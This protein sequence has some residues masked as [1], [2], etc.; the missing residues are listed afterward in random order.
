MA[1]QVLN[2]RSSK[3]GKKPTPEQIEHGQIAVNYYENN[4]RIFIKNSTQNIIDFIPTHEVDKHIQDNVKLSSG[5]TESSLS[6]EELE[7]KANETF[8]VAIGKLH[9]AIKDNEVVES[10]AFD[11]FRNSCGFDNNALY[12]PKNELISGTT[13]LSDAM[14]IVAEKINTTTANVSEAIEKIADEVER[15]GYQETTYGVAYWNKDELNPE[16]VE[17]FG[18]KDFLLDYD[19]YLID[20]TDNANKTTTPVGKL[21]KNNLLRFENGNFAPTIGITEAQ[22]AE[23]DVELYLDAEHQQKYCEAGSFNAETFYNEHGMAKLYNSDGAEVRVLRPWETVET[24]YSI[25]LG[26]DKTVYVLDNVVG[27]SG[28]KWRGVFLK[29]T[30]WDGFDVTPYALAPTGISP[31]PITTVGGKARTFLYLYKGETNCQS[32]K[33]QNNLCTMFFDQEKTYPRTND[34]SQ[35]KNK[36]IARSNNSDPS[37]P[38]PFAEGGFHARNEFITSLETAYGTKYLHDANFFGSG[39]SSNDTCNSE[40]TWKANGGVRYKKKDGAEDWSYANW[41]A[42][43]EIYYNESSGRTNFSNLINSEYPKEACMESQMAMSF[44]VETNVSEGEEFDFYGYKYFYKNVPNTSGSD[45][46]NVRVYKYM[47]Q[48]IN[49][50]DSEGTPTTWTI[51]VLLRMSLYQGVNLC[52]DIWGY[53]GGGYEQVG[54]CVYTNAQNNPVKLYLQP[55]QTLWD[56]DETVSKNDLGEFDFEKTYMYL[57]EVTNLG[58]NYALDRESYSAWKTAKGGS[59]STGE[60]FYAWDNKGWSSTLNQRVRLRCL[61]RS[62]AVITIVSPRSLLALYPVSRTTRDS[63]GSAQVLLSAAPLQA[64]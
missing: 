20:T 11:T 8:E 25:V 51:E 7:P 38:Y 28:K 53:N 39:I 3:Q 29:P 61:V 15:L 63:G 43:K 36:Q 9:K 24:K 1:K 40:E 45:N 12:K 19:F 59:L 57:G 17:F 22:R 37:L 50:Y 26:R 14:E 32:N 46:M 10:T 42:T 5:Y 16:S 49:A 52:G 64:E 2:L 27:K 18:S 21:K 35:I 30:I 58:D 13:S 54:T 55:D 56:D 4:E 6:N 41:N 44:A 48:D 31:S 62:Y 23:C 34:V 33:G 60:C 47:S